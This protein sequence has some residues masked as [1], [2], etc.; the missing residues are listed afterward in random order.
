MGLLTEHALTTIKG[1]TLGPDGR[2]VY[3]LRMR[4]A[5]GCSDDH[6]R[7]KQE[8]HPS[9]ANQ[10]LQRRNAIDMCRCAVRAF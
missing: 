4:P 6:A 2:W 1:E 9:K 8:I 7:W 5:F 3:G 10:S